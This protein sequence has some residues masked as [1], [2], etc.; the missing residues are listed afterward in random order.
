[1]IKSLKFRNFTVFRS[2]R[3]TFGPKL[4]VIIGENG[5][6]KSHVI[7]ALYAVDTAMLGE[8]VNHVTARI[9]QSLHKVFMAADADLITRS[10]RESASNGTL[11]MVTEAA[12]SAISFTL[13][14][15][16]TAEEAVYDTNTRHTVFIPAKEL[17]TLYPNFAVL[18]QKYDLSYDRTFYDTITALSLP[19]LV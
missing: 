12:S 9:R 7:K 16:A 6:G 14:H 17:L 2:A 3:F 15:G 8:Q 18:W 19:P 5:A 10:N 4:N 1:M 11:E 13:E